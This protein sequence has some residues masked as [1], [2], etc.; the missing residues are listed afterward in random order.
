MDH[1]VKVWSILNRTRSAK[2]GAR[3]KLLDAAEAWLLSQN[4]F[5]PEQ[6]QAVQAAVTD[7]FHSAETTGSLDST[8]AQ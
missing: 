2:P 8:G 3:R 7:L 4:L 1:G 6:V 5:K